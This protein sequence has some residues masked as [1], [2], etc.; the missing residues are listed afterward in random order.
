MS[1]TGGFLKRV[2][3]VLEASFNALNEPLGTKVVNL[4]IEFQY[5]LAYG[6]NF[7]FVQ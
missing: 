6:Y 3:R 4:S 5:A 2:L 7:V 1:S